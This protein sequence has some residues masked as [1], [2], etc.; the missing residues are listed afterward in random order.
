[1][2]KARKGKSAYWNVGEKSPMWKGGVTPENKRLRR[3]INFIKWRESVFKRD[4]WTCQKY[5]VK[6]GVL[7]PH[8]IQNFAE[9][10][11]LRFSVSNGVTLSERAHREF[12]KRYGLYNNTQEQMEEY[13]NDK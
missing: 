13:L 7:H 5:G 2:S 1:M 11:E 12:H 9:N 10:P 4:C 8:H 6:G 3:S